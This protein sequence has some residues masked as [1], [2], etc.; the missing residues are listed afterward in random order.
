[1][2]EIPSSPHDAGWSLSRIVG[3][4]C[5]MYEV[6]LTCLGTFG[7]RDLGPLPGK[8]KIGH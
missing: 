7:L 3:D 6:N 2:P 8:N 1:M 4:V 5:T